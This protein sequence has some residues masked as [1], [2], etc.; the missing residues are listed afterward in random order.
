VQGRVHII[1]MLSL[2]ITPVFDPIYTLN[3]NSTPDN[4]TGLTKFYYF[5]EAGNDSNDGSKQHPYHSIN[6]LNKLHL[7]RGGGI[8]FRGGDTFKGTI[9]FDSLKSGTLYMPVIIGSYGWQFKC[10]GNL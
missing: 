7:S 4:N 8:Y 9:I 5:S 1:C 6:K 3:N 2:L 10:H